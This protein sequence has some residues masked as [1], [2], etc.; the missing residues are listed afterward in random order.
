MALAI[1]V[2][3]LHLSQPASS[4]PFCLPQTVQL[5]PCHSSLDVGSGSSHGHSCPL[6]ENCSM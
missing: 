4:I 3:S 6:V 1:L 2:F 5:G